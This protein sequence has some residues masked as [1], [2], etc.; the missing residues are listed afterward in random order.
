MSV[1]T[2]KE[3]FK[4]VRGIDEDLPVALH[5]A[6]YP[7]IDPKVH[8]ESKTFAHKVVLVTGASRGIG[9]EVA[10][11]YARAGASLAL[12]ARQ[13]EMLDETK[14]LILE[15]VPLVQILTFPV[16]VRDWEQAEHAVESTIKHFGRLDVLIANAGV[17][18]AFDKR[19]GEKD[20]LQWWNTLEVNIRGVFN[21]VRASVSHLEKTNG[22]IVAT[23]SGAAQRRLPLGSDYCVSKHA[24]GRLVEYIA[25][26]YPRIK[27]FGL[28]PGTI[29]TGMSKDS[30]IPGLPAPDGPELP[31][32]VMLYLTTG[33]ADWLNGRLACSRASSVAKLNAPHRYVSSNWDMDEVNREWK[34]KIVELDGLVS[35]LCVP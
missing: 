20:P 24:L 10:L 17:T 32:A 25:A 3:L 16:D 29:R 22:Y 8:F 7:T 9:R 1:F 15:Q 33:N 35:K 4:D 31:A 12:A 11:H 5:H 14:A 34:S 26:E 23:S 28:H 27:A 6:I 30:A 19:L 13:Q 2:T 21:F 18:T